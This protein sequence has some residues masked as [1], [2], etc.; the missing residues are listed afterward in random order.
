MEEQLPVDVFRRIVSFSTSSRAL[1]D[2]FQLNSAAKE[3]T[4]KEI[5]KLSKKT[6]VRVDLARFFSEN[7][8]FEWESYEN[9]NKEHRKRLHDKIREL[10]K[11]LEKLLEIGVHFQIGE[12]KIRIMR[13]NWAKIGRN[14][15][16]LI[17]K[18]Y[19][20]F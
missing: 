20:K 8:P 15:Q 14:L 2:L 3:A 12:S 7:N 6:I 5:R 18:N 11:L 13:E 1:L 16:K 9:G 19:L 17:F 4:S 10:A